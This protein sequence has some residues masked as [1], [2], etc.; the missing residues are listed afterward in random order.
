MLAQIV[1]VATLLGFVLP[2]TYSSIG[3][4]TVSTLSAFRRRRS[5]TVPTSMNWAPALTLNS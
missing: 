1:G 4:S 2:F 3:C 5:A